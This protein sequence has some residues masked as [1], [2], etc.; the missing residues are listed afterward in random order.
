ML[1]LDQ[2]LWQME[3]KDEKHTNLSFK[4]YGWK[5]QHNMM[6]NKI[7]ESFKDLTSNQ[8]IKSLVSSWN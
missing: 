1:S 7:E 2:L 5:L 4:V 8:L 3:Y 6:F